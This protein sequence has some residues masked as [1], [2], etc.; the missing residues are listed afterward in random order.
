VPSRCARS[1]TPSSTCCARAALGACY[2][3]VSRPGARPSAGSPS[4]A[5]AASPRISGPPSLTALRALP[6]TRQRLPLR[7]FCHSSFCA[8]SFVSYNIRDRFSRRNA[9]AVTQGCLGNASGAP[10]ISDCHCDVAV[11]GGETHFGLKIY[12]IF[13]PKRDSDSGRG[14]RLW[15]GRARESGRQDRVLRIS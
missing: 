12:A 7:R 2:P 11:A 3:T 15:S 6:A 5:T 8:E 9:Q 1:P 14:H 13:Q 10:C 4:C